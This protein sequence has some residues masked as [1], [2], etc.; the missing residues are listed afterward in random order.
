M[1]KRAQPP[2]RLPKPSCS[3]VH[4]MVLAIMLCW[5]YCRAR[6]SSRACASVAS[7]RWRPGLDVVRRARGASLFFRHGPRG[8]ACRCIDSEPV[9]AVLVLFVESGGSDH[10]GDASK[11]QESIALRAGRFCDVKGREFDAIA[12]GDSDGRSLGV[13]VGSQLVIQRIVDGFREVTSRTTTQPM[14]PWITS[15]CARGGT[16]GP[17]SSRPSSSSPRTPIR[18]AIAFS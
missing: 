4:R 10:P 14:W 8:R 9:G 2:L 15:E 17:C 6:A 5:P 18:T 12:R 13:N 11:G 3:R 16:P 1:L 7:C